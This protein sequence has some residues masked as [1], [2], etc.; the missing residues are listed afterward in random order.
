MSHGLTFEGVIR[1]NS[2]IH[3]MHDVVTNTTVTSGTIN[4]IPNVLGNVSN[5][6]GCSDDSTI[7]ISKYSSENCNRN[8][9]GSV[10]QTFNGQSGLC[11]SRPTQ[12]SQNRHI[13]INQCI[14]QSTTLSDPP[15]L[16]NIESYWDNH[17]DQLMNLTYENHTQT[18]TP[19]WVISPRPSEIDVV[20]SESCIDASTECHNPGQDID[21]FCNDVTTSVNRNNDCCVCNPG[22]WGQIHN[23]DRFPY[24]VGETLS[25]S[26]PF[27]S[28]YT[29][30]AGGIS[31]VI[32]TGN[33]S[34]G[35]KIHDIFNVPTPTEVGFKKIKQGYLKPYTVNNIPAQ[36]DCF[37]PIPTGSM[38]QATTPTNKYYD[39][40]SR[41]NYNRDRYA[42]A[43]PMISTYLSETRP[44]E[45]I[46][47]QTIGDNALPQQFFYHSSPT[48][49]LEK[50]GYYEQC[51]Y[52]SKDSSGNCPSSC[53]EDM[54]NP[55]YIVTGYINRRRANA[56]CTRC[57]SGTG[58]IYPGSGE[59]SPCP[60]LNQ[61][62]D[63]H[64]NRGYGCE[65]CG[66]N[67]YYVKPT[68]A[69]PMGSCQNCPDN[70]TILT[71][72]ENRSN[73]HACPTYVINHE[74]NLTGEE[75]KTFYR[76]CNVVPNCKVVER[77]IK[78]DGII[79]N[80]Q[81]SELYSLPT[82]LPT[83][84]HNLYMN[85]VC[86]QITS[87][88]TCNLI[89]EC[90]W[91]GQPTNKCVIKLPTPSPTEVFIPMAMPT[92]IGKD[93]VLNQLNAFS[94]PSM[95]STT[96]SVSN[97]N[98]NIEVGLFWNGHPTP[99]IPTNVTSSSTSIPSIT[100]PNKYTNE[101]I[102]V[103]AH[104][105][106]APNLN[107][108][109]PESEC[110]YHGRINLDAYYQASIP[111]TVAP[112]C[113]ELVDLYDYYNKF[114]VVKGPGNSD[115][116]RHLFF[117]TSGPTQYGCHLT[118]DTSIVNC[119]CNNGQPAQE[120]CPSSSPEKCSSCNSGY[121]LNGITC[122]S[123][124]HCPN[125]SPGV[126]TAGTNE[127][128]LANPT[129]CLP[130]SCNTGYTYDINTSYCLPNCQCPHGTPSQGVC[131]IANPT[132][133][134][135]CDPGYNLDQTTQMCLPDCQCPH[136]T[137][138]QGICSIAS[139]TRCTSC[140]PGYHLNNGICEENVC[141]CINTPPPGEILTGNNRTIHSNF[142]SGDGYLNVVTGTG[143]RGVNCPTHGSNYCDTCLNSY[144]NHLIDSHYDYANGA[145]FGGPFIYSGVPYCLIGNCIP[146]VC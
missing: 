126:A 92:N 46:T 114:T 122:Q 88:P 127:C 85:E 12:D 66:I 42:F 63:S 33:N 146:G 71:M 44:I 67:Q 26:Y 129:K 51:F 123:D 120:T 40:D 73:D 59:C 108:P 97:T 144:G 138:S 139:P 101:L 9:I 72:C 60:S 110:E 131:S 118:H 137:P 25:D 116:L 100:L 69:S 36:N 124:C 22:R 68:T 132:R 125:G 45:V 15:F 145:T 86:K 82:P 61:L 95:S 99:T 54:I 6:D 112:L 130:N 115:R 8:N 7:H 13:C 48:S 103:Y 65:P 24:F 136:G 79:G 3:N 49:I 55:N 81:G 53:P 16:V 5:A 74:F 35:S 89:S 78:Y 19:R 121:R 105:H 28:N 14:P 2:D 34:E 70:H 23:G 98:E 109:N 20:C 17:K 102:N 141:V 107:N 57:E 76:Y 91:F 106:N 128:T 41:N 43:R 27:P 80:L 37:F 84:T 56:F 119:S 58:E 47:D 30:V 134:T 4:S 140:D 64:P 75:K 117:Y 143:T 83:S 29:N 10:C 1:Q 90:N 87:E 111:E 133:C 113:Q 50:P 52:G 62:P 38:D 21:A 77:C 104:P 11:T 32:H 39:F 31:N 135:S 142:L 94:T 96:C 18:P 93:S